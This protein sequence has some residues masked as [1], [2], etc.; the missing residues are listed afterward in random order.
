MY[1]F[2]PCF[3]LRNFFII[4]DSQAF[5]KRI[6]EFFAGRDSPLDVHSGATPQYTIFKDRNLP[7]MPVGYV[8]VDFRKSG[9]AENRKK[10]SK[11]PSVVVTVS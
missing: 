9:D 6:P 2:L 4:Y 5:D 8:F 7:M 1:A 11:K 10:V 3:S